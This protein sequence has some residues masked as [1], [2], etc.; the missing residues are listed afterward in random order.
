MHISLDEYRKWHESM[1]SET[2]IST[3]H[4]QP[5]IYIYIYIYIYYIHTCIHTY[6]HTYIRTYIEH[7]IRDA[8][9]HTPR[10]TLRIQHNTKSAN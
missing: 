10:P 1:R 6:M 2:P 8:N 3:H 9:Q 7:A 4:D 5:Y